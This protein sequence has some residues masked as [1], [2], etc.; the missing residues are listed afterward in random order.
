[1]EQGEQLEHPPQDRLTEVDGRA[2]RQRQHAGDLKEH[3][4]E[5]PSRRSNEFEMPTAL[6]DVYVHVMNTL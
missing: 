2:P 6:G 1:M 3:S 4:P 5:K